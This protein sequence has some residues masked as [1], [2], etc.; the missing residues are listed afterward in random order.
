MAEKKKEKKTKLSA[1][2]QKFIDTALE[3]KNVLVDAC[4]GSGKTTAIQRLCD[5][6]PSDKKI[7]YLTFSKLLKADAQQKI[8]NKN[9]TVSNYHGFAYGVLRRKGITVGV[10]EI[11]SVFL[12]VKPQI[13]HY[14][15]LILDEYQDIDQETAQELEYIKGQCPGIQ[16][17]AVGDTCQKIFDYTTL[18]NAQEFIHGF[19]DNPT[20]LEFTICYRLSPEFA[21]MLGDAWG[22]PIKGVN[23]DCKFEIMLF[24]QAAE[25]M[26]D[27]D[28][29]DVLCLGANSGNSTRIR[30]QNE[31]ED[32]FFYKYNKSTLWSSISKDGNWNATSPCKGSAVF[33]TYDGSKGMER[34]VCFI[35]D[36]DK[37]HWQVRSRI[38]QQKHEIL[39]N[40]FLVAAS[41]GKDRVIFVGR[42]GENMTQ[43]KTRLLGIGETAIPFETN[44]LY[45]DPLDISGMFDYMYREDVEECYDLIDIKRI[46]EPGRVIKAK[47][48]DGLID[49]SPCIG[50]YVEA[51]YFAGYDAESQMQFLRSVHTSRKLRI[52]GGQIQE[53]ILY[54]TAQ[55]TGQIRYTHQVDC[56]YVTKSTTDEIRERLS[57]VF[58]PFEEIQVEGTINLAVEKGGKKMLELRGRC[59]VLKENVVYEL[60]FVEE[61][62]HTHFLQLAS[63]LVMLGKRQGCLWNVRNN[64]M[65]EVTIPD[66]MAF[67]D[68]VAKTITKRDYTGFFTPK[69]CEEITEPAMELVALPHKEKALS[70]AA[71]EAKTAIR[72]DENKPAVNTNSST[73]ADGTRQALSHIITTSEDGREK[74]FA[75][76]DTETNQSYKKT[77]GGRIFDGPVMSIGVVIAEIDTFNIVSRYYGIVENEAK[78]PA[79]TVAKNA[80]RLKGVPI[81][82]E[83]NRETV[84]N[85][86]KAGLERFGVTKIAA[87]NAKFDYDHL[88]ELHDG[89]DWIDIMGPCQYRQFNKFLPYYLKTFKTGKVQKGYKVDDLLRYIGKG[90]VE[91]TH[92][93]LVDA[94]DELNVMKELGNPL[95]LYAEFGTYNKKK[96]TR[97]AP[98]D[99][100]VERGRTEEL[101]SMQNSLS[102]PLLNAACTRPQM[103]PS[104]QKMILYGCAEDMKPDETYSW[105][106]EFTLQT[107]YGAFQVVLAANAKRLAERQPIVVVGMFNENGEIARPNIYTPE[108]ALE[109]M[110]ESWQ[111]AM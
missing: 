20:E 42:P 74:Y 21:K 67:M 86:V 52:E 28:T 79:W 4:I 32:R 69:G 62:Q 49:I 73:A 53:Q 3:G 65:Y 80:L 31:V 40:I 61:L 88:P 85:T 92:N 95:S 2:Q 107:R 103:V 51:S 93:A 59:D 81:N 57:G 44:H 72:A 58:T 84:L 22:K 77:Y 110:K 66:R 12:K 34:P 89:Y 45:R 111:K 91:E 97:L 75:V 104:G 5:E 48:T 26:G 101:A 33:T 78:K 23:K 24:E 109:K 56:P 27:Y 63:Y 43:T 60:K 14:D 15:V 94:C 102:E 71:A 10:G 37:E 70:E 11:I 35:C 68:Q 16:I 83:A 96:L 46:R 106:T 100:D 25:L 38:P 47:M 8:T 18:T 50:E 98:T 87:Y 54:L 90:R 76:I 6:M 41:R 1:E 36:Y 105:L 30:L 29:G 17:I 9:T 64:E 108:K 7:L 99:A 55:E 39:R 19:M 82:T 13:P